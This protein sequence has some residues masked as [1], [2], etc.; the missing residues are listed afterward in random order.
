MGQPCFHPRRLNLFESH[1]IHSGRTGRT[2][3]SNSSGPDQLRYLLDLVQK[4][5]RELF[6][7]SFVAY[8][9][10]SVSKAINAAIDRGVDTRILVEASVTHGGSLNVDPVSTIRKGGYSIF[11]F[12]HLDRPAVADEQ[13]AFFSIAN[14]TGHAFEK[15]MEAGILVSGGHVPRN[16][17][18]HLHA[19][20][21][22]KIIQPA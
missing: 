2:A 21:E 9:V 1:S 17:R 8:D 4:A 14:L 22:T 12:I 19:L 10:P 7:V 15:N 3:A 5:K 6:I 11:E 13:V 16:L 18:A 20:I